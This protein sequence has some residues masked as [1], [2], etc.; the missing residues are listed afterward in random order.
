MC[1]RVCTTGAVLSFQGLTR[2]RNLIIK[3]I[4]AL[5]L[6]NGVLLNVCTQLYRLRSAVLSNEPWRLMS[7]VQ[8]RE[9]LELVRT[10]EQKT[11][12]RLAR[13]I[14]RSPSAGLPSV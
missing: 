12:H 13:L 7:R 1:F 11:S 9:N 6:F 3:C 10:R 2:F 8:R 14:H 5:I 4:R